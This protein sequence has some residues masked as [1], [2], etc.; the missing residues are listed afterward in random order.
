MHCRNK[1]GRLVYKSTLRLITLPYLVAGKLIFKCS[2]PL[3]TLCQG[4]NRHR[5][6]GTDRAPRYP[7]LREKITS[8]LF[9]TWPVHSKLV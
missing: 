3:I 2:R 5:R 8:Y 1:N 4:W 7:A 9:L 6:G